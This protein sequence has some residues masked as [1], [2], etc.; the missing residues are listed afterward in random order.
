MFTMDASFNLTVVIQK[1]IQFK[2]FVQW[3]DF[4]IKCIV[5]IVGMKSTTLKT[6]R[7]SD[8]DPTFMVLSGILHEFL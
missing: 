6:S 2:I 7:H 3:N 5:G 4:K 8:G 1:N